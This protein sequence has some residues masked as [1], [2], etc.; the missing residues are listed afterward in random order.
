[1]CACVRVCV[2]VCVWGGGGGENPKMRGKAQNISPK[3]RMEEPNQGS[4]ADQNKVGLA[5]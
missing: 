1:M 5:K 3:G 2:C 4:L